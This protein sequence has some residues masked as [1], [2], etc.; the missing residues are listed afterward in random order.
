MPQ[1][2]NKHYYRYFIDIFLV[3]ILCSEIL[4]LDNE[5]IFSAVNPF[6]IIRPMPPIIKNYFREIFISAN[7]YFLLR[8]YINDN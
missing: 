2:C 7:Q 5:V 4:S 1:F 6:V 8:N 3:I